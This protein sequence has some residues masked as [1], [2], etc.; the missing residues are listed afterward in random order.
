MSGTAFDAWIGREAHSEGLLTAELVARFCAT[1][2][3]APAA[4][5]ALPLGI[6]WCLGL[7]SIAT[8]DLGPDGHPPKGGLLPPVPL[9]RRMWAGGALTI[10]APLHQSQVVRRQSRIAAVTEKTGS[11]GNLCFVTV[12]HEISADGRPAISE[13]QDIVYREAAP[14]T[15]QP[16]ALTG[17]PGPLPAGAERLMPGPALLFRYSALTFNAHRIHYDLPYAQGVEG[18][19]GLVVHGPLQ[20][21]LLAGRAHAALGRPLQSFS[22]RGQAPAFA[23]GDLTLVH[24]EEG[25]GLALE[26]RQFSKPSMT[27]LAE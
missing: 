18:Y 3:I 1:L 15:A 16:P 11:S 6:H 9:P 8:G 4:D 2:G 10:R 19:A 25:A 5:G 26:S 14:V 27:A 22:F 7:E 20:A 23:G 21:T 12:T 13:R 17:D 24:R